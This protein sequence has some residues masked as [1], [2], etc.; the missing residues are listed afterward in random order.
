LKTRGGEPKYPGLRLRDQRAAT[1]FIRHA[2]S[3]RGFERFVDFV[4]AELPRLVPSEMTSYNEIGIRAGQSKNWVNPVQPP[5]RHEA[6]LRVMHQHPIVALAQDQAVDSALRLSDFM[7]PGQLRNTALYAEHYGPIGGMLDCLPILWRDGGNVDSIGIHRKGKFSDRDQALMNAL[8]QPLVQAHAN[9]KAISALERQLASFEQAIEAGSQAAIFLKPDRSIDLATKRALD[10]TSKYFGAAP[11]ERL[12]EKLE[13]WVRHHDEGL[14]QV[15][16][17]PWPRDP[18]IVDRSDRRLVV[19]LVS[20]ESGSIVLLEEQVLLI[21]PEALNSLGLSPRENAVLA[22]VANG[23]S[24]AEVARALGISM[25]TVEA[26]VFRICERLGVAN[27]TAA[28]AR[29]FQAG[30]ISDRRG[31]Q[32]A[33]VEEER[34][35]L[36]RIRR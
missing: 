11:S 19:R 8:N 25:R 26:H 9:A 4:L 3:A 22:H 13:L 7:T 35:R 6:W 36:L 5:E 15:L 27:R 32:Q 28:A 1:G 2:Y 18:L 12:P 23:H 10:W 16:E 20:S 21:A 29:A 34:G 33:E 31:L 24:N 14:Q 17:L 30:R